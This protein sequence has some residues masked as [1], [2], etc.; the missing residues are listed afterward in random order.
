MSSIGWSI[1]F[2]VWLQFWG[3]GGVG[4]GC[5]ELEFDFALFFGVSLLGV[6]ARF[7]RVFAVFG[8][9]SMQ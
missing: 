8:G 4:C 5:F 7:R 2:A 6:V 9:N 3:V 1:G